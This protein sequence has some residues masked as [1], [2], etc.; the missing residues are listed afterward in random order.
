METSMK[1]LKLIGLALLTLLLLLALAVGVIAWRF[2]PAWARQ[3]LTRAMYEQRQRTLKIDGDLAMSFYPSLGVRLG[4]ASLSEPRSTEEFASIGNA[5][6]S[7]RLLPLLSRQVVVDRVELD[8]VR[9]RIVRAKDGRFN[10]DD[11]LSGGQDKGKAPTTAG[12]KPI[13]YDIAG[14]RITRSAVVFRDDGSGRTFQLDDVTARTGRLSQAASGPLELAFKVRS[15]QPRLN[16][17]L[18]VAGNYRYDIARKQYA[19]DKLAAKVNGD[20]LG[21]QSLDA[22]I[23]AAQAGWDAAQGGLQFQ[24]L[25]LTARGKLGEDTMD[26]KLDMPRLASAGARATGPAASG[27]LRLVGPQ[28]QV[29]AKLDLSKIEGTAAMLNIANVAAQWSMKQGT[30]TA[31]G[32]TAGPAQADFKAQTLALPKL[33]GALQLAHPQLPLKQLNVPLDASAHVDWGQSRASGNFSTRIEESS[34]QGKFQVAKFAPLAAIFDLGVDRLDL[35]RLFPQTTP[36]KAAQQ[37][38][39]PEPGP[40]PHAAAFDFSFLRGLD[41]KGTVR[42]GSLK[43]RNLKFSN[44]AA[45]YVTS[46]GRL[47]L[48][49]VAAQLYG[50]TLAGS[51][52][53]QADGNRL[54][55]KQTMDNVTVGP[56]IRDYAGKDIIEGRGHLAL[57]VT[58][59]GNSVAAMRQSLN[60]SA[61]LSLH[62]GA[63]KGIDLEKTLREGKAMLK[64]GKD[65]V[66]AAN[67]NEKTDF[68]ELSGSFAIANGVAHN[69]DLVGRSALLR[70]AGAGNIDLVRE[71]IDYQVK[72]TVVASSKDQLA[73]ELADLNGLTIPVRLTG[74]YDH[75][76]YHL[77]YGAIAAAIAKQQVQKRVEQEIG[78]QLGGEKGKGLGDVLKGLIK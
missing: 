10:F 16:A 2:D 18:N 73:K 66:V 31:Q 24:D 9:A 41:L 4:K 8:G 52:T 48:N 28:K 33:T 3:E 43:A 72:A 69:D 56:L 14:V 63:V 13:A 32:H 6:V 78:K 27:T 49:P 58:T 53:A 37:Q 68:S 23:M 40:A 65:A 70:L 54:A 34:V 15:A 21:F 30:L 39:A 67:K 47:D 74:P 59:A 77:E 25:A 19:I 76:S 26:A 61:R 1:A 12:G 71:Q 20:V 60:G 7:V 29:D 5:R 46:N 11:L 17:A 42:I 55:L 36:A 62:D 44:V 75:P 38:P 51:L 35:D 45:T 50:G 22:A 57:D 64:G